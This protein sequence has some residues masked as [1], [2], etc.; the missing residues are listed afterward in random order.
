MANVSRSEGLRR[1]D[2]LADFLLT[3]PKEHFNLWDWARNYGPDWT[4]T[5]GSTAC[6]VGWAASIP[7]F[8]NLGF[9]LQPSR[10]F[11][12]AAVP[13]FGRRDNWDAVDS[14]F[15]LHGGE[16]GEAGRLFRKAYYTDGDSRDPLAVSRRIKAFVKAE[17]EKL[18][19]SPAAAE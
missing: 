9:R 18:S 8:Q 12:N 5:C 10:C 16:F 15:G 7:E 13:A 1:L 4:M 17:R 19:L 2:V 6:A 11:S 3:V 14:F